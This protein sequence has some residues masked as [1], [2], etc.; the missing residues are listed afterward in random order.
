[1]TLCWLPVYSHVKCGRL[2]HRQ[3]FDEGIAIPG[4]RIP[5]F[6]PFPNSEIPG[7]ENWPGIAIPTSMASRTFVERRSPIGMKMYILCPIHCDVIC[8]DRDSQ[9]WCTPVSALRN[10]R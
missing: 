9:L 4:F 8:I 10:V 5:G 1:M 3:V 6:R 7:L 2:I